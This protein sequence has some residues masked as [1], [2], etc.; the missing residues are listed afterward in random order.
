M[1]LYHY[2]MVN[3]ALENSCA[4][5]IWHFFT[6]HN[7]VASILKALTM[8][9]ASV[10]LFAFFVRYPPS[11]HAIHP[12]TNANEEQCSAHTIINKTTKAH[13]QTTQ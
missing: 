7:P 12:E 11:K 4:C 6:Q 10:V 13:T 2:T 3:S 9:L 5:T 8:R 1:T